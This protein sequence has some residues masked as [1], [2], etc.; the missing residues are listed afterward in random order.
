MSNR[1]VRFRA[2][3]VEATA[4]LNDSWT[5]DKVWD[6]LPITSEAR[7]WGDEIY[8]RVSVEAEEED[9]QEVVS[10]KESSVVSNQWSVRGRLKVRESTK[11]V[12]T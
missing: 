5:A 8:F 6:D 12:S 10:M 11:A 4:V 3:T 9:A 7:T 1:I 2:G